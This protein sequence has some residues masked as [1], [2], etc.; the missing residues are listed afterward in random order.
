MEG[1]RQCQNVSFKKSFFP[2]KRQTIYKKFF[3]IWKFNNLQ[4]VFLLLKGQQ[5]KMLGVVWK[6]ESLKDQSP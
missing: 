3:F 6:S 1:K 5:F 2:L 4:R